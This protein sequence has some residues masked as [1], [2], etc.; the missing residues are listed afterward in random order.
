[1]KYVKTSEVEVSAIHNIECTNF[2]NDV[3][4]DVDIV[5]EGLCNA[6]KRGNIA[7]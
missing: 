3:V 2:G 4:E 1:M 6:Y 7:A 5:N